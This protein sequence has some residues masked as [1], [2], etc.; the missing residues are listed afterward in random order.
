MEMSANTKS[1]WDVN[2]EPMTP[3]QRLR[4]KNQPVGLRNIGNT[5]YF[6]SLIFIYYSMPEF[7]KQI[8][9]FQDDMLN[10]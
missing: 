3:D 10:Q 9:N 5:C 6:N 1:P 4:E 8:L 7:V 2:V